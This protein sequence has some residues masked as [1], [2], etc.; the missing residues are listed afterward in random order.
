M[1]IQTKPQTIWQLYVQGGHHL[2]FMVIYKASEHWHRDVIVRIH[3]M[4]KVGP[5]DRVSMYRVYRESGPNGTYVYPLENGMSIRTLSEKMKGSRR[6][7]ERLLGPPVLCRHFAEPIFI[8]VG[9]EWSY[10]RPEHYVPP[11]D[12]EEEPATLDL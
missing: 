1:R 8:R 10:N 11:L 5:I 4:F 3:R 7:Y 9:H 12:K 6:L 2:P